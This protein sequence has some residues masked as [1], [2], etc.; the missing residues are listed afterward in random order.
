MDALLQLINSGACGLIA[1][2]LGW[3]V[4]DPKVHDGVVVKTGLICM[5]LGFGS[6]AL[7]LPGG[8]TEAEVVGLERSLLLVN[9]GLSVVIVGLV[10]R[11]RSPRS[12]AHFMELTR[13]ERC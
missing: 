9:A 12:L 1:V 6:V 5:A 3:I 7:L 4:L 11:A 2:V 13:D 10:W 8:L